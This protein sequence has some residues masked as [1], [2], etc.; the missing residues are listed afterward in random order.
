MDFA[1]ERKRLLQQLLQ[2]EIDESTYE[3]LR[4]RLQQYD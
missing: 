3:R 1:A 2:Q 4:A